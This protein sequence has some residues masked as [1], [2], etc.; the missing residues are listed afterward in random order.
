ML[1]SL[2]FIPDSIQ[3]Q[4]HLQGLMLQIFIWR[5]YIGEPFSTCGNLHRFSL[6]SMLIVFF[7]IITLLHWRE[8]KWSSSVSYVIIWHKI[9]LVLNNHLP[10]AKSKKKKKKKSVSRNGCFEYLAKCNQVDSYQFSIDFLKL[11]SSFVINL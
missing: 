7:I 1:R 3:N 11:S 8:M 4:S 9:M 5:F 2:T 10:G 6:K